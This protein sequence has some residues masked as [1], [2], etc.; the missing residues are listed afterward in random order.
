M[1]TSSQYGVFQHLAASKVE[2][3]RAILRVFSQAKNH[4][5]ISLRPQEIAARLSTGELH[6]R[7][8]TEDLSVV[9]DQLC[10]WGNLDRSQDT[11]D[12]QTVEEF[13]RA[14]FL[15]QFSANGE[16]AEQALIWFD[17]N[18]VRPGEL[19][20]TALD[21][22]CQTLKE[23]GVLLAAKPFDEA[24]VVRSLRE[25]TDRFQQL[26]A[27]A[28][29]FMRSM[30]KGIVDPSGEVEIFLQNKEILLEYLERFASKL[31]IYTSTISK[32]LESLEQ[33]GTDLALA[34][35][36][37]AELTDAL[38]PT[39]ELKNEITRQWQMRWDGVRNWFLGVTG[40]RSQADQLRARA[41]GAISSL[42]ETVQR[43]NDRRAHRSDRTLDF[44]TLAK[45]FAAMPDDHDAHRLWRAAFGLAPARHLRVNDATL[46]A[47]ENANTGN[48]TSWKDA[49]PFYISPRLRKT[50]RNAPRGP[51]RAIVDRSAEREQLNAYA[52]AE[53]E[54]WR[55][56]CKMLISEEPRKL[57]E[58]S[59]TLNARAVELLLDLIGEALAQSQN[60]ETSP[61]VTSED[62]LLNIVL[63]SPTNDHMVCLETDAG[64]LKGPDFR[65]HIRL[66][67]ESSG[68][69]HQRKS[70][71]LS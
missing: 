69:N 45:W 8:Q 59:R 29:S 6:N 54:Q 49:A 33:A 36:V 17:Q 19:Q 10:G 14:R 48:R 55:L 67:D 47:W 24:K 11:A 50:G 68:A 65:V 25:L 52:E 37:Q 23:L 71:H 27:R 9:L 60:D 64:I 44:I 5:E 62:G 22:I 63:E 21:D 7:L 43:L 58:F 4:F 31:V 30:Q 13:N 18:V 61:L 42:L 35:V 32:E 1:T 70:R 41:R 66:V 28:Q 39:D 20:V 56:A 51:A 38:E 12:V 2:V 40:H 15:Y 16:A 46:T 26:T 53:R 34:A 3:Y 57:S